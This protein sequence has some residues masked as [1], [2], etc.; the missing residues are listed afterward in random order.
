M[1]MKHEH[2]HDVHVHDVHVHV[3]V[4]VY[5]ISVRYRDVVATRPLLCSSERLLVRPLRETCTNYM[6]GAR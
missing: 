2:E 1:N 4:H 3:H 6:R 5:V